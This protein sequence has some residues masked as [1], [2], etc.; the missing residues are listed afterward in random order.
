MRSLSLDITSSCH[1]V[2]HQSMPPGSPN[3]AKRAK[4]LFASFMFKRP[5]P[6]DVIHGLLIKSVKCRT[7]C[8]TASLKICHGDLKECVSPKKK[9]DIYRKEKHNRINPTKATFE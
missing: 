8:M 3:T 5:V 7:A 4:G 1:A 9:S 2:H 6:C